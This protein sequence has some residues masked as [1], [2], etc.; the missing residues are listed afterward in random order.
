MKINVLSH[1]SHSLY[2]KVIPA[3]SNQEASKPLVGE[4]DCNYMIV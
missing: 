1:Y 3:A 2:Y 4:L